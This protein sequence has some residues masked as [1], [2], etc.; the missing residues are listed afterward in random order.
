MK[1]IILITAILLAG[2]DSIDSAQKR[3]TVEFHSNPDAT[4]N[5]TPT[6]DMTSYPAAEYDEKREK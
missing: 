1:A 2:C 5:P 3:N 6:P 4:P